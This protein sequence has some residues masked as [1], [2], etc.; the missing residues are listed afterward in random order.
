MGRGATP[1]AVTSKTPLAGD[2]L[3]YLNLK[4]VDGN[5]SNGFHF[6][7]KQTTQMLEV[8]RSYCERVGVPLTTLRSL[9]FLFD[10]RRINDE[11]TPEDL[12]M[13]QDD[14]V[15]VYQELAGPQHLTRGS[16]GR[17]DTSA[18]KEDLLKS[19]Q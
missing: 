10:G 4:V 2:K 3:E 18:G 7:V 9:R 6:M 14:V 5:D 17:T 16:F 12:E 13:E 15:E 1:A 8:K 11:E 19:Q